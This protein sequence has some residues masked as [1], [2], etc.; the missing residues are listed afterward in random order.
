MKTSFQ[1]FISSMV[2]HLVYIVGM[3]L[4]S[5]IKTRNYKP[6]FSSWWDKV[7]TLE[8]E[9]VFGKSTPPFLSIITL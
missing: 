2:I 6:D 7:E 9:A 3:T 4:I 1:A 8:N 5:Y